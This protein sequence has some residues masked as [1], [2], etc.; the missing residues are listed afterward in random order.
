MFT[1]KYN[2]NCQ[3]EYKSSVYI[4]SSGRGQPG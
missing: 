4:F 2:N 1:G 3:Y